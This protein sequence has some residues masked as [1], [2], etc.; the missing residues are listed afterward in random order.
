MIP[1]IIHNIWM[2]DKEIPQINEFCVN[3][4]KKYKS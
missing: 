2:G 3:S 4:V 1:K